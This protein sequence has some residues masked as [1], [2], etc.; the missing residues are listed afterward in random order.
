MSSSDKN[1]C[2][3]KLSRS[4]SCPELKLYSSK[5][6]MLIRKRAFSEIFDVNDLPNRQQLKRLNSRHSETNLML[7]DREKTF[8]G[9][10]LFADDTSDVLTQ[11][12][13][14]LNNYGN[15]RDDNVSDVFVDMTIGG[16]DLFSEDE[17]LNDERIQSTSPIPTKANKF[18]RK[19]TRSV[20]SSFRAAKPLDAPTRTWSGDNTDIQTYINQKWKKETNQQPAALASTTATTT[21]NKDPIN[22]VKINVDEQNSDEPMPP[23]RN[24]IFRRLS[25]IFLGQ[26]SITEE[27]IK[28]PPISPVYK[29]RDTIKAFPKLEMIRRS[30]SS[31]IR[32]NPSDHILEKTTIAD[33]IR[34]IEMAHLKNQVQNTTTPY[35]RQTTIETNQRRTSLAPASIFTA[36]RTPRRSSLAIAQPPHFVMRQNSSPTSNRIKN[37]EITHIEQQP[38]LQPNP[39]SISLARKRRFS[40]MPPQD[41]M[42]PMYTTPVMPR[43][44]YTKP[45]MS[46]LAAQPQPSMV[47]E[48]SD[49]TTYSEER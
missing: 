13:L 41:T 24:S 15:N 38:S 11:V 16:V 22:S 8:H 39:L 14:A 26:N 46:P 28:K 42:T 27:H 35:M 18:Q 12:V 7:I 33:L 40:L 49:D 20:Y 23:R 25:S 31:S 30:S 19:R 45:P 3:T 32:S 44:M 29:R 4:F 48:N 9:Q 10:N 1:E 34:A 43:R 6:P 5:S 36:N 17:I 37:F 2:F 21:T 47:V